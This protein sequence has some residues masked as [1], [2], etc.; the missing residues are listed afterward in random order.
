M[1][2]ASPDDIKI[3]KIGEKS[4][5][6]AVP[7]GQLRYARDIAPEPRANPTEP[8]EGGSASTQENVILCT[9]ENVKA[10]ETKILEV[11]GRVKNPSHRNAWKMIRCLRNNQDLGSLF[12]IRESY[13]FRTHPS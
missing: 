13:Y 11:D 2:N 9:V 3:V 7:P 12:D 4:L 5:T 6:F 8:A 1:L 10:L